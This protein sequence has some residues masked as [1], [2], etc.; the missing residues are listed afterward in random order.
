MKHP[1]DN[2]WVVLLTTDFVGTSTHCGNFDRD[3]LC[4]DRLTSDTRSKK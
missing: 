4:Y 2:G 1:A 3:A